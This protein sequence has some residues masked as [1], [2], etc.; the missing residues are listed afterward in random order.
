[1]EKMFTLELDYLSLNRNRAF[2]GLSPDFTTA[3]GYMRA[4][5]LRAEQA[6]AHFAPQRATPG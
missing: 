1:M 4:S 2:I 5:L 6:G 3:F